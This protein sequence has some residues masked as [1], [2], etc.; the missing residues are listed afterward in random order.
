MP[1]GLRG[2]AAARLDTATSGRLNALMAT[3]GSG[4]NMDRGEFAGHSSAGPPAIR[5][6]WNCGQPC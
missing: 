3:W 2:Q 6:R 1:S 5:L 4:G